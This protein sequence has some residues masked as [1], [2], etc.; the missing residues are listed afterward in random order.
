MSIKDKLT[1]FLAGFTHNLVPTLLFTMLVLMGFIGVAFLWR[2]AGDTGG[3]WGQYCKDDNTCNVGLVCVY[4]THGKSNV[5]R[6][7]ICFDLDTM[8][9]GR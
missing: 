2:A 7:S 6:R 8:R 4:D 3:K 5:N 9:I 1:L